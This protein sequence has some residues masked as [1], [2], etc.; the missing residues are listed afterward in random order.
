MAVSMQPE[1]FFGVRL[2]TAVLMK[3]T[4]EEQIS[5]FQHSEEAT[6]SFGKVD[7]ETTGFHMEWYDSQHCLNTL[8][9]PSFLIKEWTI[10]R[11][12]SKSGAHRGSVLTF[13]VPLPIFTGC[14][15]SLIEGY[16]GQGFNTWRITFKM[17]GQEDFYRLRNA[18]INSGFR[19]P[20]RAT[21]AKPL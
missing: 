19:N 7:Q 17:I 12:V 20:I 1:V 11:V 21:C 13:V 16:D 8:Q 6:V 3:E 4:D 18:C 15:G 10:K 2:Y 5:N 14:D 9:V